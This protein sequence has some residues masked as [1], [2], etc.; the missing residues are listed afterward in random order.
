M[1]IPSYYKRLAQS[2]KG[3]VVPHKYGSGFQASTLFF[4]FNCMIYQVIRNPTR[5]PF[6]GYGTYEADEW[7]KEVC[8][9]VVQLMAVHNMDK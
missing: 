2:I 7:E 6:P 4:D 3:L 8:Q 5:R 1:G 9:D